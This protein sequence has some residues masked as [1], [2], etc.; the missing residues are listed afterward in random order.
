MKNVKCINAEC[1]ENG[2]VKAGIK[3]PDVEIVCGQ[4]G[5]LTDPTNE[6]VTYN[7]DPAN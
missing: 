2:I 3:I 1:S 6:E 7:A 5:Q 4:C